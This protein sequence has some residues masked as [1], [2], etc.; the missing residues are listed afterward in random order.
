[1]THVKIDADRLRKLLED[2]SR[3]L[4]ANLKVSLIHLR[5]VAE[6]ELYTTNDGGTPFGSNAAPQTLARALEISAEL[7]GL[8]RALYHL[9]S[10]ENLAEDED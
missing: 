1:M 5:D 6:E 9:D 2:E 3:R 8:R 4:R 10:L 7:Q